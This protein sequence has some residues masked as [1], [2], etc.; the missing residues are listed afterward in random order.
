[1]AGFTFFGIQLLVRVGADGGLRAKLHEAIAQGGAATEQSL[2]DK[3]VLYKRVAALLVADVVR[4][5]LGSSTTS[6]GCR[7]R[8]STSRSRS[9]S[10]SSTAATAT[11]PSASAATCPRTSTSSATPSCACSRPCPC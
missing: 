7:P 8:P 2:A 4:F 10:C 6:T 9:A 5:D 1:M 3:R 11:P